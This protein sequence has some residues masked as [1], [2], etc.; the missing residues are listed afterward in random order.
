VPLEVGPGHYFTDLYR[1][2]EGLPVKTDS[3]KAIATQRLHAI[4]SSLFSSLFPADLQALIWGLQDRIDTV[5]VQS[6]EPWVPWEIC[7]LQGTRDGR[8]VEGPFFCEAFKMT[9]WVPGVGRTTDLTMSKLGV[10]APRD[11]RLASTPLEIGML[12]RLAS[13]RRLVEE[14]EPEYLAVLQAFKDATYDGIHFTGHGKFPD[15]SNPTKAEIFLTGGQ[16]L[17]PTDISGVTAN[18]GLTKPLVFL[19]ACQV[20]RQSKSLTGVGGW[21]TVMVKAGVGAFVG[22][23][24]DVTDDLALTFATQF[25]AQLLDGEPIAS[26]ART[27]RLA[28]RDTGDPTWLA[29]TVFADPA[30]RVAT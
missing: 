18:L 24:W 23:H 9:R 3:E 12:K 30:A 28:I 26:A 7:R 17:R 16:K 2:I 15:Q 1:E 21:A 5:W 6:D 19:N 14:V 20:A 11:S 13:D 27:A 29:Y 22:A 25:Y 8:I 4:G 10:I